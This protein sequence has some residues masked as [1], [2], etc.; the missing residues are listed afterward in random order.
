MIT[1]LTSNKVEFRPEG[2]CLRPRKGHYLLYQPAHCGEVCVSDTWEQNDAWQQPSKAEGVDRKTHKTCFWS[3]KSHSK[4][5]EADGWLAGWM[6]RQRTDNDLS[7]DLTGNLRHLYPIQIVLW[8]WETSSPTPCTD[9]RGCPSAASCLDLLLQKKAKV[10]SPSRAAPIR[11][12]IATGRE[13]WACLP[14]S[15]SLAVLSS[16]TGPCG[17]G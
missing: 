4:T 17:L 13:L 10:T 2:I 1:I 9:P 7:V 12:W 14:S 6:D 3:S 5:N 15:A 8:K 11:W 16:P